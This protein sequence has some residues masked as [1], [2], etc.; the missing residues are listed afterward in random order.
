MVKEFSGKEFSETVK[1]TEQSN[2]AVME[3]GKI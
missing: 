2:G 1:G 3:A